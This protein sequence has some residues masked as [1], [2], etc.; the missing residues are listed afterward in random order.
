MLGA[1]F[2]DDLGSRSRNVSQDPGYARVADEAI[3]D[4]RRK[5]IRVSGK[6]LIKNDTSHLPVASRRVLAVRA[7][8][9]L[10]ITTARFV[11]SWHALKR[12][13]IAEA[14]ALQIRQMHR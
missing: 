5:P 2:L 12:T 11:G 13:Y 3:D 7:Q 9:T 10:P 1:E 6:R 8:S 14:H 4:G